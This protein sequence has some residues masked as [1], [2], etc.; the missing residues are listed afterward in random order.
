MADW[1]VGWME[2]IMEYF[3]NSYLL[4]RLPFIISSMFVNFLIFGKSVRGFQALM[5]FLNPQFGRV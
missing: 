5:Q 3:N 4:Y 2:L 1:P